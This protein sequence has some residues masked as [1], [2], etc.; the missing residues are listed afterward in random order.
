MKTELSIS[1]PVSLGEFAIY[2]IAETNQLA[3][4]VISFIG[5]QLITEWYGKT[6]DTI[7][8]QD[9][10]QPDI[11]L[12]TFEEWNRQ[13][14]LNRRIRREISNKYQSNILES[15]HKLHQIGIVHGS[16]SKENILIDQDGKV[17]LTN[18]CLSSVKSDF[19]QEE[20][21]KITQ[22]EIAEVIQLLQ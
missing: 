7:L 13:I 11:F 10:I 22:D 17:K 20:W 6:L 15:Y 16:P 5:N 1:R 9:I 4:K 2:S 19:T 18:F 8:N 14:L 12:L 21:Q 3:P